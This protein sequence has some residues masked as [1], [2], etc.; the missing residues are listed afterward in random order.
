[1]MFPKCYPLIQTL[2]KSSIGTTTP[3][4]KESSKNLNFP[5]SLLMS[6]QHKQSTSASAH[7]SQKKIG[8]AITQNAKIVSTFRLI[9]HSSLPKS[10][11]TLRTTHFTPCTHHEAFSQKC[12]ETA[13]SCMSI[14]R[15][16]LRNAQTSFFTPKTPAALPA[17]TL[18]LQWYTQYAS[19]RAMTP[20]KPFIAKYLLL[21]RRPSVSTPYRMHSLSHEPSGGYQITHSPID[22]HIGASE[23]P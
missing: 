15:R 1:M 3:F 9:F 10:R 21:L 20:A 2:L 6:S 4:L 14:A 12:A 5:R 19:D 17:A 7:R 22:F 16:A 8:P 18:E 23:A 13:S 11:C